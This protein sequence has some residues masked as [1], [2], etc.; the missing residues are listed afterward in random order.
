MGDLETSFKNLSRGARGHRE[1][2]L[3]RTQAIW[4]ERQKGG[5]GGQTKVSA[6]ALATSCAQELA[7]DLATALARVQGPY[8][9]RKV[10]MPSLGHYGAYRD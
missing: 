9:S 4:K 3:R 8:G 1:P 5:G 6:K 7:M 2:L 10:I